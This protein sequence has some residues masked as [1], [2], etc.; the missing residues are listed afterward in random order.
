M[1]IM[2][3][4]GRGGWEGSNRARKRGWGSQQRE[5]RSTLQPGEDGVLRWEK[6]LVREECHSR[7]TEWEM[8]RIRNPEKASDL[9]KVTSFFKPT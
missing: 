1:E 9:P 8:G 5:Q 7:S 2:S 6:P 4:P 3:R